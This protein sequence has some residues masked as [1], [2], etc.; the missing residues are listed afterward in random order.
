MR[1]HMLHHKISISKSEEMAINR[2][3]SLATMTLNE[4]TI[5]N[6]NLQN[7]Q[8]FGNERTQTRWKIEEFRK[9]GCELSNN[10]LG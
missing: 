10:C 5:I 1:A 7:L 8:I 9:Q 3:Y 2:V 4:N 6:V